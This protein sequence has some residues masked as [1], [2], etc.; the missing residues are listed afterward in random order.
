[1]H[2][3]EPHKLEETELARNVEG[4]R[5][6]AAH[7]LAIKSYTQEQKR[8]SYWRSQFDGVGALRNRKSLRATGN[9]T[10]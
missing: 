3:K 2:S 5:D 7:R 10:K 6:Q 9:G 8:Q 1:M 4:F